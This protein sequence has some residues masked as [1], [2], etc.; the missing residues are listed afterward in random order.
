MRIHVVLAV[1]FVVGC[2]KEDKKPAADP[3]ATPGSAT[4]KPAEPPPA[5]SAPAAEP[6][7]TPTE[8]APPAAAAPA[9]KRGKVIFFAS[10]QEG[11][12]RDKKAVVGPWLEDTWAPLAKPC[13]A[14]GPLLSTWTVTFE[15]G[16]DGTSSNVGVTTR[17]TGEQ[18]DEVP[19]DA[20]IVKCVADSLSKVKLDGKADAS[21]KISAKYVITEP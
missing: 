3:P 16:K 5:G 6:A 7:P 19:A 18:V 4:P 12:A 20:A 8:P 11:K 13:F 21:V 1:L 10:K 9:G 14:D 2:S 15:L 17:P